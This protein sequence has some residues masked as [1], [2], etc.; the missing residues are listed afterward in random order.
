MRKEKRVTREA[1][2]PYDETV[3]A[4]AAAATAAQ[5]RRRTTL[6]Y[7]ARE[8]ALNGVNARRDSTRVINLSW[9]FFSPPVVF[10]FFSLSPS[11]DSLQLHDT[12]RRMCDGPGLGL[13][14]VRAVA[15]GSSFG[16]EPR[17]PTLHAHYRRA[18]GDDGP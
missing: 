8:L 11:V 13:T 18:A 3:T 1:L 14:A 16:L 17:P 4:A 6:N 15:R 5:G 2:P 9:V 7:H 10:S 12:R